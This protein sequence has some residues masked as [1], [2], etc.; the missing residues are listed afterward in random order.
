MFPV[1]LQQELPELLELTEKIRTILAAYPP[2]DP[3]VMQ[4]KASPSYQKVAFLIDN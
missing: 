2:D 4:I 1:E 3:L